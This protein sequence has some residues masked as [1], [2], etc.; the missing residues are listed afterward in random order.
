MHRRSMI[1]NWDVS[2]EV[3]NDPFYHTANRG[4]S[5]AFSGFYVG[6]MDTRCHVHTSNLSRLR[7]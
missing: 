2:N 5:V 6:T 3:K 4:D 1:R 7:V